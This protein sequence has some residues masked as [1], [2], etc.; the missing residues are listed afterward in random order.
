VSE[1]VAVHYT[2]F[3]CGEYVLGN[4]SV[5]SPNG[6]INL[7]K[8]LEVTLHNGRDPVSGMPCGVALGEVES[9]T[10]FEDVWR[11]YTR[12]IDHF[13]EVL[14]EQEKIEYDVAGREAPFLFLS[15]LYDD[16]LARGKGLFAGGVR[17]LG[18]TLETYGNTNTA[19]ALLAIR[20]TVFEK[21]EF[22]LRQIVTACDAAFKGYESLKARLLAVPKY[23][24]DNDQADAM[25]IRVHNHI[26]STTRQ[27]AKRV[28]LH[29]YQVVI[30]NNWANT[31]LGR[32]TQASSDGRAAWT[33]MANGNNPAPGLDRSGATAF[34]NS[35]AK[36]D[37]SIH[38]GAVQ[39]MK[40]SKTM[41]TQYRAKLEALLA[42][43]FKQGGA[44][45]M[46]TV[47]S[48]QDL[49][50]AMKEPAAWGHLMVRVGGFSAR[51]IDL[52]HD[53]QLEVLERTL[54]E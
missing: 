15:M 2:P 14:A 43:Y 44:Q 12:Q 52:P 25:A 31:L 54:H 53:V 28:G 33:S 45:A 11:A 34:L 29:S 26:C 1:D 9:F 50:S 3:G 41:F 48:R 20:E 35:L 18:G 21:K 32:T 38:A 16:C 4:R 17:Y 10:S 46:I 13:V 5:G 6:V 23:G 47:V 8:G 27:Q 24:N 22:T 7:L 49:E 19:D 51:F 36:L 40:F 42:G 39:N 30:I 37:P